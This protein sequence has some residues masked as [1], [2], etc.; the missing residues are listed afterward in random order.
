MTRDDPVFVTGASGFLAKHVVLTLLRD[1]HAVRASVRDPARAEEVRQAV[2]PNLPAGAGDQLSFVTLD[3][4]RDEGWE[5]AMEDCAALIHTASPFPIAQPKAAE[6]LVRPAVDGTRRALTAAKAAGIDR[7]VLTSSTV[8]II[9]PD[10]HDGHVFTE[11][12]W[13]DAKGRPEAPYARSKVMAERAAWEIASREGLKLTTINPSF[14]LGP[15]LDSR[16]GSSLG[17]VRRIL[18]GRDP[19]V[20][21]LGFPVVDVRDVARAHADALAADEAAGQRFVVSAGSLWMT[22]WGRILKTVYPGR[23]MPTMAAPR[24]ILRLLALFD[25]EVRAALPSVGHMEEVSAEKAR[26]ILGIDFIP[27]DKALI[28]AA[29]SLVSRGLV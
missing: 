21:K 4:T 11:D 7:V 24:A 6:D 5:R 19:M 15:T 27:P 12:D 28:A 2:L 14:I 29:E 8:A 26:R 23:R 22:E 13:S 9:D 16:F 10:R 20:P 3:L 18:R 17:L 1:G 25:G